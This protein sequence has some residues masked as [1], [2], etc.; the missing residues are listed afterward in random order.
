MN[1][2]SPQQATAAAHAEPQAQQPK[3]ST[4]QE[5]TSQALAE[6]RAPSETAG[7][8]ATPSPAG[9]SP[10]VSDAAVARRARL[11]ELQSKD[12]ER[13]DHK[14]RQ[15]QADKLTRELETTRER[16]T[17]A[18]ALA[19][20]RI[21][22]EGLDAEAFLALA[23][24]KGIDGAKIGAWVRDAMV[25]P[26]RVAQA[27]MLKAQQASI[28]PKL[29]ALEARLA[30]QDKQIQGFLAQQEHARITAQDAQNLQHF[31]GLVAGSAE[32]APLSAKLL[33]A[34]PEE[35]QS[36]ADAAASR[37]AEGVGPQ[38]LL[39]A[40]EE[41]LDGDGR[42]Y[43]GTYSALYG[44]G[45]AHPSTA[46]ALPPRA[47]APANTISNSLAAKRATVVDEEDFASFDLNERARRLTKLLG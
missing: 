26:N 42:K 4:L 45:E 41:F 19:A 16:A 33:A 21:D 39:D 43:M 24:S 27:A 37:L 47:T 22:I 23:E 15:A 3:T 10:A 38:A 34:D 32:H 40:I 9:D 18:E 13:V 35:F 11:A 12:R 36:I 1:N 20:K 44:L 29:S 14:Q 30:E 5:R 28:D 17:Q 2:P 8:S 7:G 25:D 46:S 6:L 31:A